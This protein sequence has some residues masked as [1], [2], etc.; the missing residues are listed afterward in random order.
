MTLPLADRPLANNDDRP[1]D[2]PFF[3]LRDVKVRFPL[4][5]TVDTSTTSRIGGQIHR[6]QKGRQW[7]EALRGVSLDVLPGD[8][9]GLAGHNGAGKSTLLQVLA[10]TQIPTSGDIAYRGRIARLLSPM[11][12]MQMYATGL[13]N[14]KM[15]GLLQG[16]SQQEIDEALPDIDAF[17]ELGP[18]M[19]V[20]MAQYSGGMRLRLAF[21][22]AT[23]MRP[24]ILLIDEWMGAGDREF[25]TKAKKRFDAFTKQASILVLATHNQSL[26][27]NFCNI[28]Y[29]IEK[30]EIVD[31]NHK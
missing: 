19:N 8:R 23:A 17:T 5:K 14:I 6:D 9:V 21:A 7:I 16:M 12:G 30:G 18:F 22:I 11:A 13:E 10:G 20:P 29:T 1:P 24:D 15:R 27:K 3:S 31:V 4:Y 2:G 26:L 25:Q 28:V